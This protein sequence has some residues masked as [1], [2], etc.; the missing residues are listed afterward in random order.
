M[1]KGTIY[2]IGNKDRYTYFELKKEKA[3]L[4]RLVKLI[5]LLD[6]TE[7]T[8]AGECFVEYE[9]YDKDYKN[10]EI[11]KIKISDL[12]DDKFHFSD[13]GFDI[14]IIFGKNRVFLIMYANK[15]ITKSVKKFIGENFEFA[16]VKK[17]KKRK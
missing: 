15:L 2:G 1:K 4:L 7:G 12:V 6:Y 8:N 5:S 10:S 11:I 9:K 3:I 13:K 14:D 16:K 17:N